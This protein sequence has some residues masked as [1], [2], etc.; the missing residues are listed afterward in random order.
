MCVWG[1]RG[2]GGGDEI[3][4]FYGWELG[5]QDRKYLWEHPALL[6]GE[7]GNMRWRSGTVQVNS[8]H[9]VML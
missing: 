7:F 2:G 5:W 8:K 9:L 1:W 6:V 3:G 4:D